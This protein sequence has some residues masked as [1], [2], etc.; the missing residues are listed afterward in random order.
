MRNFAY[1]SNA[2]K[3]IFQC[4]AIWV[5]DLFLFANSK[6]AMEELKN[7]IKEE[8]KAKDLGEAKYGLGIEIKRD[9][10]QKKITLS[11]RGYIQNILE[12]RGMADC[13]A[14]TTPL[15]HLC[16]P[17][18]PDMEPNPRIVSEYASEIG[19]LNYLSVGTRPDI[20]F[21]VNHLAQFSSNPS[22]SH[23]EALKRLYRYLKGTQEL[24]LTYGGPEMD[25]KTEFVAFADADWGTQD[26]SAKST[27]GYVFLL[28]GGAICWSS[29]KQQV[30]ALST[31]E[32]EYYA[33]THC[34]KHIIWLR[35]LMEEL[36]YP[37][38]DQSIL[39]MDN[40]SA[41]ALAKNPEFHARTKHIH[42]AHHFLR[43]KV[44]EGVLDLVHLPTHENTAD[45]FTK[46]LE[47]LKHQLFTKE[48]GVLPD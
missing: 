32:A 8:F 17:T 10:A 40:T 27:S 19:S 1:T 44:A 29:K 36:G 26:A 34:T 4:A 14:V 15:D 12:K 25:W 24:V 35:Y 30:I 43:E 46:P 3:A 18:S 22:K 48:V 45:I 31:T 33:G 38:P 39:F 23:W 7:I 11:Q 16:N 37:Q 5:D 13:S 2:R 41:I 47:R 28:A 6:E 20:S 21:T 42:R 9:K